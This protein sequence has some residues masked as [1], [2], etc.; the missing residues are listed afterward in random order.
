MI[1][2]CCVCLLQTAYK[3]AANGFSMADADDG[4]EPNAAGPPQQV[5]TFKKKRKDER[6]RPAYSSYV[7]YLMER[8]DHVANSNPTLPLI[9]VPEAFCFAHSLPSPPPYHW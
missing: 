7:L 8:R 5:R 9:E 2:T 4:Q 6:V 1:E 3:Q